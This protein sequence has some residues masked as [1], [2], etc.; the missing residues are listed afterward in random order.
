MLVH[1]V[2]FKQPE[3]PKKP[4][5]RD[6]G[7]GIGKTEAVIFTFY[8]ELLPLEQPLLPTAPPPAG[9]GKTLAAIGTFKKPQTLN[10]KPY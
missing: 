4:V 9:G 10:P 5:A 7:L 6:W 8:K 3:N 2:R 1:R